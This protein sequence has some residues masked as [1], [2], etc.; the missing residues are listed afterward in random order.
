[1]KHATKLISAIICYAISAGLLYYSML[2]NQDSDMQMLAMLSAWVIMLIIGICL[3]PAEIKWQK[4]DNGKESWR[5]VN[6]EC[7]NNILAQ[8]ESFKNRNKKN[9]QI[10]TGSLGCQLGCLTY[11]LIMVMLYSIFDNFLSGSYDS[12]NLTYLSISLGLLMIPFCGARTYDPGAALKPEAIF[13]KID[14]F[15]G[16]QQK[17]ARE[18]H[19]NIKLGNQICFNRI[20]DG[21]EFP[22][23]IKLTY[24]LIGGPKEFITAQTVL[25]FNTVQS[26]EYPYLYS[27]FVFEKNKNSK[28]NPYINKITSFLENDPGMGVEIQKDHDYVV[29]VYKLDAG[30]HT[31]LNMMEDI[32]DRTIKALEKISA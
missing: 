25:C 23:D 22:K 5:T 32:F 8:V 17:F 19:A 29:A 3:R 18:N 13:K 4:E 31:D 1:M 6:N 2:G 12:T 21:R 7:Y 10:K 15:N 14:I 30:Y 9:S 11:G 26:S 20:K 27:V 24:Q 28:N 16:F